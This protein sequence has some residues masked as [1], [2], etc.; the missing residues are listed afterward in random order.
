[1]HRTKPE[2]VNRT[3]YDELKS[4]SDLLAQRGQS[5]VVEEDIP[6]SHGRIFRGTSLAGVIFNLCTGEPFPSNN[7][8]RDL[9]RYKPTSRTFLTHHTDEAIRYA[10]W[11]KPDH[12]RVER[13]LR[14]HGIDLPYPGGV[15]LEFI[16]GS[17]KWLHPTGTDRWQSGIVSQDP[18]HTHHLTEAARLHI[19]NALQLPEN[20]ATGRLLL[21]QQ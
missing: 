7:A 18:L 5:R 6:V 2:I 12:S 13:F 19:L 21:T 14:K 10:N 20:S 9:A 16:Q 1:M 3:V 4:R 11:G 17:F 15:V 8:L